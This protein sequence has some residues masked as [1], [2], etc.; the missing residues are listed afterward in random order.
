MSVQTFFL[1]A[2][3]ENAL[4]KIENGH[5][6]L[7]HFV[8]NASEQYIE[9][10]LRRNLHAKKRPSFGMCFCCSLGFFASRKLQTYDLAFSACKEYAV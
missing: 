2:Y 4:R 7:R 1:R 6:A 10:H 9:L 3:C 5:A 8:Q